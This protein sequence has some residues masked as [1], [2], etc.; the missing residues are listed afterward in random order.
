MAKRTSKKPPRS[1]R[2]K[3]EATRTTAGRSRPT[4]LKRPPTPGQE[5]C[6]HADRSRQEI[7]IIA[8]GV[9]SHESMVLLC[10]STDKGYYYLPGGHVEFG[11]SAKRAL[12]REFLEECGRK[13]AAGRLLLVTEGS[14]ATRKRTHHEIN[15]VFHVEHTGSE[16]NA[17]VGEPPTVRSKEDGI[18][19]AWV[20]HAAIVD[21]DVRPESI[22]AWLAAGGSDGVEWVSSM[23]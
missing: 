11:E 19:F 12:E 7:E 5:P 3:S 15:L 6:H 13:V 10:Q 22:K 9:W 2:N 18:R 20:D 4:T 14:F 21:L 17:S 16:A 8:R 23:M 1:T